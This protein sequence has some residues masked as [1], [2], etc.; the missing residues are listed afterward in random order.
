MAEQIKV[1]RYIF[2]RKAK[3]DWQESGVGVKKEVA[4]TSLAIVPNRS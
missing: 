4:S 1:S 3:G 2:K